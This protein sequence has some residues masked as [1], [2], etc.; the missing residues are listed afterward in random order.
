MA[1]MRVGEGLEGVVGFDLDGGRG[2]HRAVVDALVGHEVHHHT[3]CGA[4]AGHVLVERPLDGLDAGQLAGQRRVQVDDHAREPAEE[5][6]RE[7]A[8]P[9][10]EHHVDRARSR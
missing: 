3:G 4:G 6:H 10:G 5:V 7:D 8:H 9:A 1:C 2:E